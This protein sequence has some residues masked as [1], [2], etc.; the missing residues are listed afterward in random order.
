M[1]HEANSNY[2]TAKFWIWDHKSYY[3]EK[4]YLCVCVYRGFNLAGKYMKLNWAL[5]NIKS[6]FIWNTNTL[7]P[8]LKDSKEVMYFFY[9][10]IYLKFTPLKTWFFNFS[11]H[12]Y[13]LFYLYFLKTKAFGNL[14]KKN[15]LGGSGPGHFWH[16][17]LTG[18]RFPSVH[19]RVLMYT[20]G[21]RRIV[22]QWSK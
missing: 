21:S 22:T 12:Q 3:I 10:L 16:F 11:F 8:F 17:F 4:L 5:A 15:V 9:V 13:S 1:I 6:L 2:V 18:N 7:N 19:N 20:T 14:S